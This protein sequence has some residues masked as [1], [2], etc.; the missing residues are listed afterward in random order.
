M[1]KG[2]GTEFATFLYMVNCAEKHT[3]WTYLLVKL[4]ANTDMYE[5]F[6]FQYK[7]VTFFV[8][9]V[10]VVCFYVITRKPVGF[11]QSCVLIKF[12]L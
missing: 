4:R 6:Y 1:S 2:Y 11:M 8:F 3:L 12:S 9:D 7:T 10:G 5:M